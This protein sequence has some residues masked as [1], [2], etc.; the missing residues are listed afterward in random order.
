[1]VAHREII[2]RRILIGLIRVYQYLISPLLGPRCRFYPTCSHYAVEAIEV[3]GVARG[4][5]LALRRVLRCHPWHPGGIDPVP[6]KRQ[7]TIHG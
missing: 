2:M 3:H 4:S 1:L 5:Y 7:T 6:E